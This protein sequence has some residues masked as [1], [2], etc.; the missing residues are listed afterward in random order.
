MR[1][2]LMTF[3]LSSTGKF[4]MLQLKVIKHYRNKS[5]DKNHMIS[6]IDVLSKFGKVQYGFMIQFLREQRV[7]YIKLLNIIKAVY[8][9]SLANTELKGEK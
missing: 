6:S 7:K 3:N 5:R 1:Q 4:N 2:S 8:E 9:I